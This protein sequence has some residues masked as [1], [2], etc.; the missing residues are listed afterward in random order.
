[1]KCVVHG[2]KVKVTDDLKQYVE[3]KLSK[4]DKYFENSDEY[5]AEVVIRAVL[6]NKR[7]RLQSQSK[8]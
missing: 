3:K 6:P 5:Q 7:L 2:K 1:M 4:L 8:E